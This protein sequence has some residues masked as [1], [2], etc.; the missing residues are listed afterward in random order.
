MYTIMIVHVGLSKTLTSNFLI[1]YQA[2]QG[3]VQD[4]TL[5]GNLNI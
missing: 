5:W 4:G 3:C 2:T 1:R